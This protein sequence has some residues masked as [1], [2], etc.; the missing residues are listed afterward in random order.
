[1][2]VYVNKGF[3]EHSYD[4]LFAYCLEYVQYALQ[5]Q[6]WVVVTETVWPPK[7]K[8]FTVWP[9]IEKACRPLF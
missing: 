5:K 8:V 9:F 4:H 2:S 1:M 3:L 7:P 6:R